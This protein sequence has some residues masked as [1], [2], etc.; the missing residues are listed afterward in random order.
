MCVVGIFHL[1]RRGCSGLRFTLV[2]ILLFPI[3]V[4]MGASAL[5]LIAKAL[6]TYDIVKDIEESYDKL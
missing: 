1:F 5:L 3:L 6:A 2:R 4:D